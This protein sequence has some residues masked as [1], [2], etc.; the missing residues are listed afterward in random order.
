MR[1]GGQL[2]QQ[3]KG[4]GEKV[5]R[6]GSDAQAYLNP[7]P[8]EL[9]HLARVHVHHRDG[10]EAGEGVQNAASNVLGEPGAN[11]D[12]KVGVLHCEVARARTIYSKGANSQGMLCRHE[13]EPS[14]R[15]QHRNAEL[16]DKVG[17]QLPGKRRRL[18][19]AAEN[20][21]GAFRLLE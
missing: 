5:R 19:T 21:V 7:A 11:A 13:V 3:R 1:A 12:D 9:V 14:P 6:T 20:Q 16:F 8:V 17:D 18:Q 10:G 4:R 15:Q 2:A